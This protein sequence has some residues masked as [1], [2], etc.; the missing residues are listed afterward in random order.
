[1]AHIHCDFRSESL[2]MMTTLN[3]VLPENVDI[4][5]AKV[6]YLLHGRRDN[7]SGWYRFTNVERYARM[8]NLV[9][10]TPEVQRSFYA[11]MDMGINYFQYVSQELPMLCRNLFNL[12]DKRE[13]NYIMGLSMGGY[14]AMKCALTHPENYA[15]VAAFSAVTDIQN[16]VDI[17]T[18]S[19]RKEY[20]AIFGQDLKVPDHSNLRSLVDKVDPKTFPKVITY[21]G[22]QDFLYDQNVRFS[23]LLKDKGFDTEFFHWEGEHNWV[24]WDQAV[25]AAINTLFPEDSNT[26][27]VAE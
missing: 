18:G 26:V 12:S 20:A 5:N 6:I 27:S 22:E 21:C 13:N 23:N 19:E 24:F 11:D 8:K 4:H 14:G 25:E 15:G 3:V 10:V 7:C 16:W 2:E 1:M 9:L 17:S